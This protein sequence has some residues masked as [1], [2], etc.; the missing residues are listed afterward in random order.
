MIKRLFFALVF[1]GL[2]LGIFTPLT[3]AAP[4]EN[5]QKNLITG[6]GLD[7]PSGFEFAP[8]GRIFI[9]E[10]TGK[11]K[12][13]KDGTLLP[14]P[15]TELPSVATGDRGLIGIAFDP[16]FN[17]NH[18]VYFYY[19]G[20][21]LLNRLV[22]FNASGDVGTDG[23]FILFETT[24]PSQQLHVGGSIRFGPDGKIYFA[25]GDNGYPPNAQ[26]LTNPHGKI[27][28]INRDGSVPSDNPFINQPGVVPQIWAYGFRNP[29]RFQFDSLTGKLYGGDVGDFSIE[30]VNHIVKGGN[31]GWSVCEGPCNNPDFIDPIYS[32]NHDGGSAAATGGPIYRSDM[33]PAE[34]QGN[35]FFGDYAKSFI[36]RCVLDINGNCSQ[37]LD[38]DTSAGS[39]V[40]MKISPIDGSL[41]YLT[42]IPGRLY[43]V[44]YSL[45]NS[46]PIPNATSNV[47]KGTDPLT[48]NF[49]SQ[50]SS[51]PENDQL[52]YN[53]N[54]SDGTT[55][56]EPNPVK[57][58]INKGTYEVNLAVSDGAN[59][60]NAVPLVIQVGLTPTVNIAEPAEGKMYRAGETINYQI[61]SLDGAGFDIND[62]AIKT[63]VIFHHATH[64]HPFLDDVTGRVGSFVIPNTGE[65]STNTYYE[66]QVTVTDDNGLSTISSRNI[67]PIVSSINLTSSIP[68][69]QFLL[70]GVPTSTNTIITGVSGFIREIS[71]PAIQVL[72]GVAY[73]FQSWSDGGD[74]RHNVVFEDLARIV[75]ITFAASDQYRAEYFN[76]LDLTGEPVAVESE[77]EIDLNWGDFSPDSAVNTDNFSARFTKLQHFAQGRYKFTTSADDGIRVFIDNNLVINRWQG[78]EN[79]PNT[80]E[81]LLTE[82]N[83]NIVVEYFE[84]YGG[85]SLEFKWDLAEV[86]PV[87]SP[88]PI[89]TP[90]TGF[91]GEY[92]NNLTLSGAA[93]LTRTDPEINFTWSDASPDPII[94][95]DN[96]S[97]RWTKTE[98]FVAG[99]HE[100]TI[101]GDDGIRLFVDGEK[102]LDK[103]I[104]QPS[105]THKVIKNLTAGNHQVV[106]EYYEKDGGA[107]AKL[108][109]EKVA[110]IS[111]TPTPSASP[112]IIPSPTPKTD[113]FKGEY[114]NNSGQS[115]SPVFLT[116]P[117]DLTRDDAEINF[118]WDNASPDL[119]INPDKFLV[120]WTKDHT[121]EAGTYKFITKSD[122]GIKVF[123]DDELL[124][125]Q[126]ND[127][128][129]TTHEALKE[130]TA[131]VHTIKVEYYENGGGAV[132]I[133]NFAKTN[134]PVPSPTP[135]PSPT[136]TPDPELG[137]W[138]GEYFDNQN[139]EG[140]PKLTRQDSQINFLW[141]FDAPAP[142]IPAEH[143]SVRW[144]KTK[145]Y[146]AG[147]YNF[148]L[149][150]DDGIRFFIDG[151]LIFE[152][153][154]NHAMKIY[155]PSVP[156]TAGP[157]ILKVEYFDFDNNAIAIVEEN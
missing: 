37:V 6:S 56:T 111:P 78:F 79:E 34:Y 148:T 30:E 74:P 150:S 151:N 22:R 63:D 50:G 122:D 137:S 104:D 71:A 131:G 69:L 4:P 103:W 19:T 82:G 145:T 8:D 23:P 39:V 97:T 121:F 18:Y 110:D 112:S 75:T 123:I 85:A 10:R 28:R 3:H 17:T 126:W 36:K 96:F 27:L 68:G 94:P 73:V 119:L 84:N 60:S 26:N 25:V 31:Y 147:T 91:I 93:I 77:V 64:I 40:E 62:A 89:P 59:T 76:N 32:Y 12:I 102:I 41:W 156:L 149:K 38:F 138:L 14:T 83:H 106:M 43:K 155:T 5:F 70:D 124:I 9:L 101:T 72:N 21:D 57:T 13:V 100:F 2:L 157:H 55:S 16:D 142:E 98:N 80:A 90:A 86:Q 92:F 129:M 33:F 117:A 52:F 11:V 1:L 88:T 105:T 24:S 140:T 108:S 15:F 44:T 81:I 46:Y 58:F 141:Q 7:G 136:P 139:L 107:I 134:D 128:A 135:I 61:S 144:T 118:I 127:H 35:L 125:D 20:L 65:A 87:S 66:L 154:T 45:G 53:W 113:S 67:Y 114:W 143:F 99:T 95:L 51:D 153:W 49:S 152:D 133:F 116:T 47:T 109:Y 48:V 130:L 54:F 132:A 146:T 42:Y 115:N 120:R 29:W